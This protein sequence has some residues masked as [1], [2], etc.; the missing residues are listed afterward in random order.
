MGIICVSGGYGRN[1]T[2][3]FRLKLEA[4]KFNFSMSIE[5]FKYY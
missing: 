1:K 4:K 3:K 2:G 5:T